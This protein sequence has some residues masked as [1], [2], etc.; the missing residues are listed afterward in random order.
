MI[1]SLRQ[2]GPVHPDRIDCFRGE[3]HAYRYTLVPGLTLNEALTAPLVA[4][5]CR[6]ATITIKG[7]ARPAGGGHARRGP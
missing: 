4:A 2:P 6:A 1:R 3:V 7:R 5:G